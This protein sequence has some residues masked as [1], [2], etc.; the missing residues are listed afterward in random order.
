M[1]LGAPNNAMIL[2][3]L[4]QA[5]ENSDSQGYT[6]RRNNNNNRGGGRGGRGKR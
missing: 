5:V 3:L 2:K 4:Q 6:G 1:G